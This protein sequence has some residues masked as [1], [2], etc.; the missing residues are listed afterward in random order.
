MHI[1]NLQ[2]VLDQS[3]IEERREPGMPAVS[4]RNESRVPRHCAEP[5]QQVDCADGGDS[6]D[7]RLGRKTSGRNA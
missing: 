1:V 3:R 2:Q 7:A 6:M 4:S 5:V